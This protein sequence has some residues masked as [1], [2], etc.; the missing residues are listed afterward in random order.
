MP[1]DAA[2][3]LTTLAD[4][5]Y[6]ADDGNRK[7]P[8]YM[9]EYESLLAHRRETPLRLLELGV[10]SGASL[11]IWRDYLPNA[12]IVGI[13]IAEPPSRILGQ[14]RMHFIRGSQDD[15]A[16]LDLAGETA[17]GLFDLIIDDA[18]H[19]GYLT[20]RSFEYLFPRWLV[21]GGT[22]VIED[23]GTGFLP[24]YPDGAAYVAPPDDDSVP[25]TQ[26]FV[27]HQFG[28]V[29]VVK[30]FIDH[31]MTELMT[32]QP[33]RFEIE[34]LTILTNIAFLRKAGGEPDRTGGSSLGVA[35]H[36]A[37]GTDQLASL[38][39]ELRRQGERLA[40]MEKT[41]RQVVEAGGSTALPRH[42]RRRPATHVFRWYGRAKTWLAGLRR[43]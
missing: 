43:P 16:V 17:G 12:T 7:G 8:G 35:L 11:L 39:A 38:R 9:R 23:F 25:E 41:L 24:A 36:G 10:S 20:K 21:P 5:Y 40:A 1:G 32:G 29:G 18:S 31:M 3:F 6:A 22:Y 15:P 42:G 27:S 13:D 37:Q 2:G 34:R 30:Q 26:C 33:P 19:L 14:D 4:R 28:M